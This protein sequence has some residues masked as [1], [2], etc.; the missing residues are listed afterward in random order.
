VPLSL[1]LSNAYV[2]IPVPMTLDNETDTEQVLLVPLLR[3]HDV[4]QSGIIQ[5]DTNLRT[6]KCHSSAKYINI[7]NRY[8]KNYLF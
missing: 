6:G 2:G 3:H 1:S 5:N 8:V 7:D 4:Q